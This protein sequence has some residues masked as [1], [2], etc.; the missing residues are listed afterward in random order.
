[1]RFNVA[2]LA[3]AA[4]LAGGAS[5]WILIVIDETGNLVGASAS[6]TFLHGYGDWSEDI[7]LGGDDVTM[8]MIENG[9]TGDCQA[10]EYHG[11]IDDANSEGCNNHAHVASGKLYST[12][13]V[14]NICSFYS[15]LVLMLILSFHVATITL[16]NG[17]QV[18]TAQD[19][20]CHEFKEC[21]RTGLGT[22]ARNGWYCD[23]LI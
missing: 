20:R 2:S 8:C 5:A 1:M 16:P 21:I 11:K 19:P 23:Q 18:K 3:L 10:G 12:R 14:N 17:D 6:Q 22:N 7:D 15:R 4:T 9:A 13:F